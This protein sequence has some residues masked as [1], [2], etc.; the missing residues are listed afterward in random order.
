MTLRP[1]GISSRRAGG[2]VTRCPAPFPT[3]APTDPGRWVYLCSH[4]SWC[5]ACQDVELQQPSE[6]PGVGVPQLPQQE[7]RPVTPQ[8]PVPVVVD[9]CFA[10]RVLPH[11]S[12]GRPGTR[13]GAGSEEDPWT[14]GRPG[15]GRG[16]RRVCVGGSG[17]SRGVRGRCGRGHHGCNS[18]T[19]LVGRVVGGVWSG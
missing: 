2:P 10:Q 8:H 4:G 11:R 12:R 7:H 5:L 18:R 16:G 6:P 3:P 15:G 17:T 9:R 1:C 13:R 14:A 19:L